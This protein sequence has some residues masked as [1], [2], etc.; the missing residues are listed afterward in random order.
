MNGPARHCQTNLSEPAKGAGLRRSGRQLT[1]LGQAQI[2]AFI[3]HY[4]HRRYHESL[5]NLTPADVYFGR[6][7]TILLERER[8]KRKTFDKR[9]LLHSK[10]AA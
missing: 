1:P 6:G 10:S 4:N 9:R 3:A 2:D 7:Q 8:T 5:S